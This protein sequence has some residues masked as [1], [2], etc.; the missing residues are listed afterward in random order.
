MS[1]VWRGWVAV[2]AVSSGGEPLQSRGN[3]PDNCW[4]SVPFRQPATWLFLRFRK[5]TSQTKKCLAEKQTNKQTDKL[6]QQNH[7]HHGASHLNFQLLTFLW[8]RP[9]HK[10]YRLLERDAVLSGI[11]LSHY[12]GK[13]CSHLPNIFFAVFRQAYGNLFDWLSAC[14]CGCVVVLICVIQRQNFFSIF[15][16]CNSVFCRYSCPSRDSD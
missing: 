3:E 4:T 8:M 9:V 10:E 11:I 6:T 1:H 16:M 2:L 13:C 5:T 12:K 15:V 7:S 14:V